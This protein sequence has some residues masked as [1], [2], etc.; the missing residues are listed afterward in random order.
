MKVADVRLS[1]LFNQGSLK[2]ATLFLSTIIYVCMSSLAFAG[3]PAPYTS[4]A[5]DKVDEAG[6]RIG[7]QK[8]KESTSPE[9]RMR[10]SVELMRSSYEA[11]GYNYDDTIVQIADDMLNHPERI[12]QNQITVVNHV[13]AGIHVMMSECNYQKVDC[14]RFFSASTAEAIKSLMKN[15]KFQM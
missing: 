9:E 8:I 15:T 6:R 4:E 5:E 1:K 12:P 10:A 3:N 2:M 13:V 11:A 7:L 14:L